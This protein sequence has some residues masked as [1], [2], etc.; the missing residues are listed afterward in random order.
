MRPFGSLAQLMISYEFCGQTGQCR[1]ALNPSRKG[2]RNNEVETKTAQ[3]IKTPKAAGILHSVFRSVGDE[4]T[5]RSNEADNR[6]TGIINT[7]GEN[8]K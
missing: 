7:L 5:R 2:C 8:F 1:S 3:K 6:A 4:A